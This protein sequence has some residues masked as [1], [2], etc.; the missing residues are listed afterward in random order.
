MEGCFI[1]D[2]DSTHFYNIHGFG[3]KIICE[4][5]SKDFEEEVIGIDEMEII[6]VIKEIDS[7]KIKSF[8]NWKD[9]EEEFY[10]YEDSGKIRVGTNLKKIEE[11]QNESD[12]SDDCEE[13]DGDFIYFNT[14]KKLRNHRDFILEDVRDNEGYFKVTKKFFDKLLETS[15]NNIQY[16]EEKLKSFVAD[17]RYYKKSA[18]PLFCSTF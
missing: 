16:L 12:E 10:D 17:Q 1:C 7:K 8:F 13:I 11:Y 15:N 3:K 14:I 2:Y 6:F 4:N 5:C 18:N 9:F